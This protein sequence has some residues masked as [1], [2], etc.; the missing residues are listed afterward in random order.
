MFIWIVDIFR[1]WLNDWGDGKEHLSDKQNY[2]YEFEPEIQYV[3]NREFSGTRG[4]IQAYSEQKLA[5]GSSWF[6]KELDEAFKVN[7]L[8]GNNNLAIEGEA[9]KQLETG[10]IEKSL[11]KSFKP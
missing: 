9:Q 10:D 3:I 11:A 5:G 1:F 2:G 6:R 8:I 4:L 7:M